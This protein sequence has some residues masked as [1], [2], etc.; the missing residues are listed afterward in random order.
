MPVAAKLA[1][2]YNA[3]EAKISS[4]LTKLFACFC[5]YL[6]PIPIIPRI[7]KLFKASLSA[8]FSASL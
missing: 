5:R 4:L 7:A 3:V 6:L 1:F 2:L 8:F